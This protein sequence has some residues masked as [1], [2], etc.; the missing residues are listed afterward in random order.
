LIFQIHLSNEC[1][2]NSGHIGFAPTIG[3]AIWFDE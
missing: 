3:F 2:M 1:E